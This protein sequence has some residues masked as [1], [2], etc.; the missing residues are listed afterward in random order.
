LITAAA[1]FAANVY[2]TQWRIERFSAQILWL[3]LGGTVGLALLASGRLP[4]LNDIVDELALQHTRRR[5][6]RGR[7]VRVDASGGT[8]IERR[9]VLLFVLMFAIFFIDSLGFLRLIATPVYVE[10]AWQS[11]D[12]GPHLLIAGTHAVAAVVAGVLYAALNERH[13][14]LWIFGIFGLVHL[15]YTFSEQ[16]PSSDSASLAMPLLYA[17]AVSLYTV[18]NFALWADV[19]TPRTISRNAAIGVALSGWM[20]TF[21]STALAMQWRVGGMPLIEHL[22][23]VDALS[24]LFFLALLVLSFFWPGK[25]GPEK[26]NRQVGGDA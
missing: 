18:L 5:F 19:S 9:L 22:R 6:A 7:F 26:S 21:V 23:I 10:T 16:M 1:Y 12:F 24:I 3:M 20:A 11:P 4:P 13:L 8:R 2:S 15:M 14:F 25:R 17:V